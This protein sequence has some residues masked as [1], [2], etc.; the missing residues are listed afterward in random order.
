MH[1]VGFYSGEQRIA[2]AGKA[3]EGG[4]MG[5]PRMQEWLDGEQNGD[6]FRQHTWRHFRGREVGL[7]VVNRL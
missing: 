1:W 6:S 4:C 2:E 5:R 7:H 3:S